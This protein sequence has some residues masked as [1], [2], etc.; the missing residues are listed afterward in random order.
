[1]ELVNFYRNLRNQ[2]LDA[3]SGI[4]VI[5]PKFRGVLQ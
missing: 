2:I 5:P 4:D 1:M 3:I